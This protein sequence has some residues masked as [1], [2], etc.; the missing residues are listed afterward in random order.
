[1]MFAPGMVPTNQASLAGTIMLFLLTW[2]LLGGAIMSFVWIE[3]R[4]RTY[5]DFEIQPWR[6]TNNEDSYSD[7]YW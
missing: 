6:E 1:M 5:A 2:G 7:G 4:M 3:A